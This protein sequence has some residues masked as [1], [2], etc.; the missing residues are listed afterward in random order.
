MR[1]FR[2]SCQLCRPD[3]CGTLVR[4]RN[5]T[6]YAPEQRFPEVQ[7]G[8]PISFHDFDFSREIERSLGELGIHEPTTIQTEVIPEVLRGRNVLALAQTGSGKTLAYGA[9]I[10]QQLQAAGF[11]GDHSVRA[12]VIVPTRELALQ[13][14]ENI[15]SY[16]EYLPFRCECVFGGVD[17][18]KQLKMLAKQTPDILVSTPGRLRDILTQPEGP[19]GLFDDCEVVVL[20]EADRLFE[21]T[22][23]ADTKCILS[24]VPA[25]RRMLMFSA[26]MP[27]QM[28]GTARELMGDYVLKL[29]Q[30][31]NSTVETIEQ[32]LF[33]VDRENKYPLLLHIL[34]QGFDGTVLIFTATKYRSRMVAE[35]LRQDGYAADVTTAGM[36]MNSRQKKFADL[37]EGKTQILVSTNLL[38]RGVDA[39]NVSL[40][41]QYDIP[42]AAQEYIHRIGRTGR[43]GRSGEAVA[44]SE[45]WEK[46]YI[47]NIEKLMNKP[48]PVVTEHP[49]PMTC[50]EVPVDRHGKPVDPNVRESREAARA[51]RAERMAKQRAEDDARE[52][53]RAP[54][55]EPR[56]T[57]AEPESESRKT[58]REE[59]KPERAE[60]RQAKEQPARKSEN[61]ARK[62]ENT[63]RKPEGAAQPPA[64]K[65]ETPRRRRRRRR[66]YPPKTT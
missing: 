5:A 21:S 20:D 25:Q 57:A 10:L 47:R 58:E 23:L 52:K 61:T 50:F 48:I 34:S 33:Y 49:F 3:I 29:A 7:E 46:K 1:T 19:Q 30:P 64:E 66:W 26:T 8:I 41:V 42:D 11:T 2:Q 51:F 38:A 22:F 32:R 62:Q 16:G 9:P 55:A 40:I 43:A 12:L 53:T 63:T 31:R 13:V 27:R 4:S 54:E 24:F 59:R 14:R 56:R 65:P 37:R 39:E 60:R 15:R 17:M 44:F 28:E 35:K 36:S 45:F 6:P 18:G